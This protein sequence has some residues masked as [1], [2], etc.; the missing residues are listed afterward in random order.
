MLTSCGWL[1]RTSCT[2]SHDSIETPQAAIAELKAGNERFVKGKMISPNQSPQRR[3]QTENGQKPF[4]V[5]VACSDSRV[6][7]E[8]I[9]DQGI[10][11]IFVI[12]TAGNSVADDVVMGSI[13][14]AIDH[15]NTPLVVILGHQNCGGI[16]SAI[17]ACSPTEEHHHGKID[18][19]LAVIAQDV[20]AFMGHP[21][22]LDEAIHV[23]AEAQVKRIEKV[24]YLK[25]KLESGALQIVS[26][27]YNLKTGEVSFDEKEL[28]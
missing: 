23:N 2:I 20:E 4:A 11:D 6:P 16:T 10:G 7:V 12:R 28:S 13:D 15:L 5:V 21:E 27:Y 17:A 25:D 3:E 19:L 9:F 1:S 26:A 18:Q 8:R 22:D 14:Y 24:N